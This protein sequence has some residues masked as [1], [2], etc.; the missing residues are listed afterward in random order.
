M[1]SYEERQAMTR[2]RRREYVLCVLD[3][4][5]S[6]PAARIETDRAVY[7]ASKDLVYTAVL[8]E[9][10][11]EYGFS[12]IAWL[13]VGEI[14]LWG[15][16]AFSIREGQGFFD[17]YPMERRT[18]LATG[19]RTDLLDGAARRLAAHYPSQTHELHWIV[20]ST[21]E[22][23]RLYEALSTSDNVLLRGVS[24]YLKS[25]VCWQYPLFMEEMALNLHVALEAGLSVLRR[26][27]SRAARRD[28]SFDT[29]YE[30]VAKTFHYGDGLVEFWQDR[31][32]D[33]NNLMHP[34]S[35]FGPHVIQPMI[36]DDVYELLHPMLSL[37]RYLLIGDPRP[38][39]LS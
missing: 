2:G 30:F 12:E 25:H 14:R 4:R 27:L 23:L 36:A 8:S 10:P 18:I 7:V 20:P 19:L 35:H 33:R 24:C 6:Y 3:K 15:A 28:V 22:V 11:N 37:Y 32:D 17:F 38:Y 5:G 34:D 9:P 21:S 1:R 39:Q 26:R 31:R 13:N 16:I 29:V